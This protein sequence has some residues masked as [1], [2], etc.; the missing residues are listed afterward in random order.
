MLT[1][2]LHKPPNGGDLVERARLNEQLDRNAD[3]PLSLVIAPAG[4]GKSIAVSLWLD[5]MSRPY[6]W[7]SLDDEE[8]DLTR[9][10]GYALEAIREFLS[11]KALDRLS[12]IVNSVETPKVQVL[13]E[14]WLNTID[15]IE[16]DFVL[17]LDDFHKI[18]NPDVHEF[19]NIW[20]R[21][22]PE[23]VQLII[24]SRVDPPLA[25]HSH[26]IYGKL[27]EIRLKHLQ[28]TTEET[29]L[30]ADKLKWN[31]RDTE[32]LKALMETTE[33][34][35]VGLRLAM[36]GMSSSE[37]RAFITEQQQNSGFHFTDFLVY[38]LLAQ[39]DNNQLKAVLYASLFDRLSSKL[40]GFISDTTNGGT[41]REKTFIESGHH[42]NLFLIPLDNQRTWYRFHHL[43]QDCLQHKL[44]RDYSP[45]IIDEVYLVASK[46][47]KLEGLLDEAIQYAIKGNR[48]D[49]AATLVVEN[50]E[51]LINSEKWSRLATWM[52]LI[53]S[54]EISKHP[55]LLATQASLY[56]YRGQLTNFFQ[57][58]KQLE[59]CIQELQVTSSNA[60]ELMG[61]Y[62]TLK[63]EGA[64]FNYQ[65]EETLEFVQKALNLLPD[66][67]QYIRTF[68]QYF[69]GFAYQMLGEYNLAVRQF[70]N[71]LTDRRLFS[72]SSHTR[73]WLGLAATQMMEG[74]LTECYRSAQQALEVGE[75][76]K[77]WETINLAHYFM[78][79]VQ[80]TMNNKS[81]ALEHLDFIFENRF[82]ARSTYALL[83]FQMRTRLEYSL[84]NRSEAAKWL[85]RA[86]AFCLD[87]NNPVSLAMLDH[88]Y[89]DLAFHAQDW[90]QVHNLKHNV[91]F[92]IFPIAWMSF[93]SKLNQVVIYMCDD[94][95]RNL[96][97]AEEAI[98]TLIALGRS[99]SA[100]SFL[101]KALTIR[102]VVHHLSGLE[103]HAL[104][105]IAE[106][107]N[108]AR[109]SRELRP[110][111]DRG[112][113]VK[114][115]I[116]SHLTQH[117]EDLFAQ[118]ILDVFETE[119]EYSSN[120]RATQTWAKEVEKLTSR[121]TEVAR[122][123][124]AG[125]RNKE[126]ASK[127]FVSTNTV[128]KHLANMYR[129]FSVQNRVALIN[130]LQKR[131]LLG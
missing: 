54:D 116:K 32:A 58:L 67:A 48:A 85:E 127:L 8:N 113:I 65:L 95:T 86:R 89:I 42:V 13:A 56:D 130:A 55:H 122:L 94:E 53:P 98:Q 131:D 27:G 43:F 69:G 21:F 19:L 35:V 66:S 109:K 3:K 12:S 82:S 36:L 40:V 90:E 28:F 17:V 111:L 29:I 4:Y 117:P 61:Y 87:I 24:I 45:E 39:L 83:S 41:R 70:E 62:Y 2:K 10:L 6:G 26:H 88:F 51:T 16:E 47:F 103:T 114:D 1:T 9:F 124:E 129:K 18:S 23:K 73:L 91:Q 52:S 123:V 74:Q 81:E 31:V 25:L 75:R 15:T 101:I 71:A 64:F 22:P 128:K 119:Q 57:T 110:F 59:E 121:E 44:K 38:R 68:C 93:H 30:L 5:S 99:I 79:A 125:Y 106:S 37:D 97:K 76:F 92:D 104:E 33:G 84:G 46:W 102:A 107:I 80:Y 60:P 118:E 78:A 50:S 120:H 49:I 63:A 11:Q 115:I 77:M 72:E 14:E 20:L 100:N 112:L 96:E 105:D 126:I 108:L 7:V 34:W